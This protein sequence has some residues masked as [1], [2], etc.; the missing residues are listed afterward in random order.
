MAK[1]VVLGAGIGGHTTALNLKRKLKKEGEIIVVSPNSNYQWVPSNIWV[2]AGY[3]KPEQVYFPLAPVYEKMGTEFKQARA[4]SIHP[5][6]DRG[7]G[8]PYVTIE[9][10]SPQRKG[11]RE[12]VYY[13]FL[14]NATGPKLNWEA[15]PGMGPETGNSVSICSY[16]HASHAYAQLREVIERLKRGERQKIVIGLGHGGAT[17]QGAGLEYTLNVASLI[18]KMGLED[19][20]DIRYITNEFFIGDLG[21][22]GAYVKNAGYV[23]HTKNIISALFYEY[24]IRWHPQSSVYKV[25]P[26]KIYYET[27]GGEE[28]V[29]EYDFAMLIP[30]FTGVG[31][32]GV[33][34]DGEDITP[35]LF[36]PNK[37]MIVDADYE[38]ASKPYHLWSGEDWP[39]KLQHPDYPNI[40]AIGIAFAPPHSISKP[41]QTPSGRPLTPA[42]PRT[43]MPSAVMGH[44]TAMNIVDWILKGKPSFRHKV[45]MAEIASICVVSIDY[46]FRGIAGSMSVYPTVPDYQ[47]YPD[48]GRDINY[49]IGEVGVAGH[50]FKYLMHHLFLWK[51][52]A[53]PGWWLIPD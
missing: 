21:M 3:M 38:S 36:K 5:E 16:N 14:V 24:G 4:I 43:G 51:A 32:T 42:P 7:E 33:G 8:K 2:G 39:K 6:G 20:A 46:G 9:Y 35:K 12:K 53:K 48:F 50:W 45:S 22:G 11:E 37:F 28:K 41:F 17:C 27:Y 25:E 29:M 44:G 13:D 15:T 47:K 52:K 26:G 40:F 31:I 19:L 23:A 18:K 10:V 34:P 49:T 1:V 30:Q